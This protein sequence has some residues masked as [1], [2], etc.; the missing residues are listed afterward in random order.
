ME[1]ERAGSAKVVVVGTEETWIALLTTIGRRMPC[2]K[3]LAVLS[4]IPDMSEGEDQG[5]SNGCSV[6]QS[7]GRG[8]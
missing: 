5:Q 4:H 6:D 2:R 1:R 8:H 7:G 3:P